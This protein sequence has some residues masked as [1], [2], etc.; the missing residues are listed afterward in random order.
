MNPFGL[1]QSVTSVTL[2]ADITGLDV[3]VSNLVLEAGTAAQPP[4]PVTFTCT[5]TLPLAALVVY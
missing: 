5:E 3:Q 1:L 2:T 4:L